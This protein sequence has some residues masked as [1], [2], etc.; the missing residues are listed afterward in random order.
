V[1][2]FGSYYV[3]VDTVYTNITDNALNGTRDF[4][5][6]DFYLGHVLQYKSISLGCGMQL[7]S[8]KTKARLHARTQENIAAQVASVRVKV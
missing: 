5:S 2:V 8:M 1:H 4:F 6:F 7:N 3:R